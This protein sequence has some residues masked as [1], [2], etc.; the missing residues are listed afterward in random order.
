[1]IFDS[2]A[3]L[4]LAAFD[5]DR[6]EILKKYLKEGIFL[7]NVGTCYD[8]SLK[9]LEIAKKYPNCWASI[10]IHPSHTFPFKKDPQEISGPEETLPE[11]FDQRFE[12]LVNE[13]KV[14][15]IGECG[16]DF[17]YLN[18]FSKEKQKEYQQK[19]I[20]V[21]IQQIR[22]AKEKKLP[23]IFHVRDLYLEALEILEEERFDQGGVFHFFTGNINQ[24]EKILEK[25][26][27]LG[28]SGVITY[29]DTLDAVIKETP[30]DKILIETDSPYVAPIPYRGRRNEPGY[31]LEVAKK[32][33]SI[34]NLLLEQLIKETIKNASCLFNI[35]F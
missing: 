32:I 29:A 22:V 10:G 17:S 12:S 33:A 5:K 7:I 11:I 15:A 3:H 1:M 9:A 21:F 24:A 18:S 13:Q 30:L 26:Y 2:H 28:F 20:E 4:N 14:V 27:Y 35:H 31:V 6:D 23:M 19:Q 25:G 8:T 16:L 34:K